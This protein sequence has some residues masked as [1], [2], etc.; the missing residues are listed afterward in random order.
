MQLAQPAAQFLPH[1]RIERAERFVEQQNFRLHR[2][3]AGQRDA[4]AL[5]AGKLRRKSF[6]QRFKLD[7]FQQFLH[8]RANLFFRRARV[9]RA[10]AQAEG[11][12]L[13][14]AHVPEQRV[15]LEGKTGLALARGN[16]RHVLAVK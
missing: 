7:E 14:N 12:V 6:R 16:L 8:A 2:E 5:A 3:R 4:L 9:L 1:L 11:D 10:D 15:M 13:K